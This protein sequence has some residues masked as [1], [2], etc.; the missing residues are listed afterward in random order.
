LAVTAGL[1]LFTALTFII[2]LGSRTK[3]VFAYGKR[4]QRIVN[5]SEDRQNVAPSIF[6]DLERAPQWAPIASKMKKRENIVPSKSKSPSP[7]TLRINRKKRLSPVLSPAKKRTRVAQIIKAE[8]PKPEPPVVTLKPVA[9]GT[10]NNAIM[11]DTTPP[12]APLAFFSLNVPGSPAVSA[13]PRGARVP[14][15]KGTPL[16]LKKPF[17]PFIDM[18]IIVLDDEGKTVRKERRVSRTDVESNPINQAVP[19]QP[20]QQ[21]GRKKNFVAADSDSEVEIVGHLKPAKRPLRRLLTV[22]SDNSDSDNETPALPSSPRVHKPSSKPPLN[23]RPLVAAGSSRS[24]VEVV[25]PA[26]PYVIRPVTKAPIPSEP[27]LPPISPHVLPARYQ[28]LSSPVAKPRQLTP[29][30]GGRGRQLFAPPSPPS[31]F[32]GTDFDLSLDFEELTLASSSLDNTSHHLEPEIPQYLLPLLEECNQETQ[33]PIDF[34]SFIDTFPY[35]PVVQSDDVLSRDSTFR[36]IGEASYSEVFG[37]GDVVLKVIPLRDESADDPANP[38]SRLKMN[39]RY[40]EHGEEED[41]PAPSDAKDVRKEMIVTRAMG[42]VCDGFVKL[43]R[44]YI[45]RGK[46][47]EVLLQLWDKYN[48]ER[49]SESVR[50]GM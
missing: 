47:P 8:V 11:V 29:I 17:S 26:L 21:K 3:Q 20:K 38:N 44:T 28:Q 31:P 2:M 14:S 40:N 25:I 24:I 12:R 49:G 46:Y 13:K 41:G 42:D 27:T 48:E 33:G 19:K 4:N 15:A 18:D 7:K 10:K 5:V 43:L 16:R 22:Y 45:V 39:V 6:D 1:L 36:K 37:I 34:S 30:R 50:P 32:I 35:D 9:Q 23:P